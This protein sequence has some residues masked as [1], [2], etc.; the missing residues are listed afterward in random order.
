MSNQFCKFADMI[1]SGANLF[2]WL[3]AVINAN[4]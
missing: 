2:R 1:E 3:E 4:I